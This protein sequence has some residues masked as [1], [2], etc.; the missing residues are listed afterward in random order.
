MLFIDVFLIDYLKRPSVYVSAFLVVLKLIAVHSQSSHLW[1]PL[2]RGFGCSGIV[3]IRDFKAFNSFECIAPT[4]YFIAS[5]NVIWL[6][7][8]PLLTI[9]ISSR[10][11]VLSL[12]FW[13]KSKAFSNSHRYIFWSVKA[14]FKAVCAFH[15]SANYI[16]VAIEDGMRTANLSM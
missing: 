4:S 16:G 5:T 7:K 8:L 1:F 12:L 15:I 10:K 2:R 9:K 6:S 13:E 3:G 11:Q 14:C